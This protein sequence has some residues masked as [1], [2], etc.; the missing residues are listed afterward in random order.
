MI[1]RTRPGRSPIDVMFDRA[2]DQLT[3]GLRP[4]FLAPATAAPAE[5]AGFAMDAHWD[6]GALVLT[7]DLPG[8]NADDVDIAV[9]ERT[10]TITAH[11]EPAARDDADVIFR[12]RFSGTWSRSLRLGTTLDPESVAASFDNGV[13]TI[14]VAPATTAVPRRVVI[15]RGPQPTAQIEA[16]AADTAGEPAA[17]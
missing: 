16:T 8:V 3:A 5:V 2:F 15:A 9:E 11:R 6:E 12:Q 13:L 4:S 7:V 14:R 1:V 10:L 17:E